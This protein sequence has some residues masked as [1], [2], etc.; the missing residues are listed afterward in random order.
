MAD[1]LV[2]AEH[3]TDHDGLMI[4][5]C[6]L[7][8]EYQ[9]GILSNVCCVVII[10]LYFSHLWLQFANINTRGTHILVH[11]VGQLGQVIIQ[12]GTVTQLGPE[13]IVFLLMLLLS[14]LLFFCCLLCLA[15]VFLP[16]L[17]QIQDVFSLLSFL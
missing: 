6:M 9:W 13:A 15:L 17:L 3:T 7:E 12:I 1:S 16:L 2:L 5:V 14:C 8:L 10:I 4:L 11:V